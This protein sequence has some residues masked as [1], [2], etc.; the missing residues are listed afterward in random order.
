VKVIFLDFDGVVVCLPLS[1]D[2]LPSGKLVRAANRECV[3]RLNEL[4][5]RTGAAVVVSSTWRMHHTPEMLTGVLQRAGFI[6]E[7]FGTTPRFPGHERGYEIACWLAE[8][9][10]SNYVVLD[11]DGDSANLPARNWILVKDGWYQGGLQDEHVERAVRVL[12]EK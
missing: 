7:V 11:D 6:G 8:Y 9:G 5:R 3:A 4:V 12:G 1:N 2:S 10:C